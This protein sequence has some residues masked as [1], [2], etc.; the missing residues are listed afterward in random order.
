MTVTTSEIE[1]VCGVNI[2]MGQRALIGCPKI[3]ACISNVEEVI[4]Y[5]AEVKL[6]SGSQG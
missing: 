5:D 6:L 2:K 3:A 4:N 1:E